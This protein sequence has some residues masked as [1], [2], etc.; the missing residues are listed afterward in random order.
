VIPW[1]LVREIEGSM[2]Y[3]AFFHRQMHIQNVGNLKVL[4]RTIQKDYV[5]TILLKDKK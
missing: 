2:G 3:F 1:K 4:S 5:K